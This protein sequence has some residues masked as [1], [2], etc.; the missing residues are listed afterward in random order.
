MNH[1]LNDKI[2]KSI[3]GQLARD[4]FSYEALEGWIQ[5]VR[6]QGWDQRQPRTA[7]KIM[8][9]VSGIL[10]SQGMPVSQNE[11]A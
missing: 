10:Q 3:T 9:R 11:I 4:K 1:E 2:V 7:E 6:A 8:A 5:I